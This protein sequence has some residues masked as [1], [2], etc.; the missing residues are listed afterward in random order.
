MPKANKNRTL[1]QQS[2]KTWQ[3]I[4]EQS[5]SLSGL[6]CVEFHRHGFALVPDPADPSPGIALFLKGN[7]MYEDQRFCSCFISRKKT[8]PHILKLVDLYR[9]FHKQLNGRT[10]EED[11]R[12]SI[13]Y[14]LAR[15][16][17]DG[18]KET[19]QSVQMHFV[20]QKPE[21]YLKVLGSD[22]QEML[23]YLSNGPDVSRF[24]E[25][26]GHVPKG[27][28]VPN[29]A[30]LLDRLSLMTL[31]TN[32]RTMVKMGFKSRRQALEENAWFRVSYHGYREL[33]V[34]RCTFYP[35]IEETTGTFTVTCKRS[36][37]EPIFRIVIPRNKVKE[38]LLAFKE[39]LPNQH[40][41]AI[42]PIPLKSLFKISMNTELDL[43]VRPII[44]VLQENGE[45]SFF[46]RKDLEKFRY[47]NLVY[48]KELGLLAE[49]EPPGK[50]QRK[51]VSPIKM[52]LKKSQIPSF[53]QEFGE[54]LSEGPHIVDASVK[55][56]KIF[57]RYDRVEIS[58]TALDR[59][60]C[61][62][63]MSYSFG[64]TSISLAEI[65]EAK[66]SGHRYIP[67]AKGWID[68]QSTDFEPLSHLLKTFPAE[69]TNKQS[70]EIKLTRLDLL[71]LQVSSRGSLN[72]TGQ[73]EKVEMTKKILEW[74]PARPMP[75]LKGITSS[76]RPYQKLGL[77]WLYFL[78]ENSL[79]G[80]L[81]DEMGLGKTHQVIALMVALR[82]HG[83]VKKPFLVICPATVLN[84]WYE[85][86]RDHAPG[87]KANVFHGGQRNLPD[88]LKEA[89]V[90]LTTYGILRNDIRQF[91]QIPFALAVF[92]EIQ[93]I[94]NPKAQAYEAAEK[95]NAK[96]KLGLTG[97]PIENTLWELKALLD[98]TVSGYL[99]TDE[100]FHEH[101]IRPMEVDPLCSSQKALTRLISPF[102]LRRLKK[103]VLDELPEKIEDIR[104]CRLSED[105]V[106][107]YR[108]AI[109]SRGEGLIETLKRD[110][111]PVPYMHVFAL[112]NMLKQICNHPAQLNG[113]ADDYEQ[114]CSGKWELFK[115]L[116]FECLDSD[117]KI[118]IYSQYLEMIRIIEKFLHRL[119]VGYV[120]LTGASRKRGEIIKRFKNDPDCRIYVGSLKAGGIGIDLVAASMVI[121]YDRWWNAAKED[122]ATDR[123]HRI[124]Q[125]RGVQV[126]K[127][128]TQGT[129]EEKIS[130]IIEKKR[131][132]MDSIVLEDDP[133]LLK[134]FSR[135]E[136]IE[137]LALP[138]FR[139][140]EI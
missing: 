48:I 83:R 38:V 99:G 76:L 18:C 32:E 26:F 117:Q 115:E 133:N 41:L 78:F 49:L 61:W 100:D 11:F 130:A 101:Y 51:F 119:G 68:C 31:S 7:K 74:R 67:T 70:N 13:W 28:F 35:A 111:K 30:A 85:K 47:G 134:S 40:G 118:V 102:I 104:T 16:L 139:D 44:H 80:L 84:H 87:L 14:H 36:E 81:C 37:K 34:D 138:S 69:K 62:L 86:I 22:G 42:H 75:P 66:K 82:E 94:K 24:I 116:V 113:Q 131:N 57:K 39:C 19:A 6:H 29:R 72:I 59:D 5:S 25:R 27:N 120:T 17:S 132:L 3:R 105:Q 110:E 135:H 55:S 90:L 9:A 103:T 20:G 122:Q 88:S 137:M 53:L 45:E 77:E 60:W 73:G 107:L 79:G 106:K 21:R 125:K 96:I 91:E 114:Y 112:L 126:F 33:G 10:P 92:D 95:L 15:I 56:L 128:V 140:L 108:D 65:L 98:L 12:S 50:M 52:V 2:P 71:R 109:A 124:G 97:T 1:K 4:N 58:P 93:Y 127:L 43:E 121:H 123:V 23:H 64:N 136:L 54:E 46:E 89:D 63:S 129:L 8:C